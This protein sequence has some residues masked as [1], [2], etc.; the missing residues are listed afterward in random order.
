KV[1]G[2]QRVAGLTGDASGG[3]AAERFWRN[4]VD[5]RTVAI[6]GNSVREH[7]HPVDDFGDMVSDREGPET[8]NTYNMLKLTRLLYADSANTEYMEY[9]ERALYNHILASQHPEHGG[10][11]Y[12]TPM[13]PAHY[14]MY[15][16]PGVAMW[17]CVGSGME[18]HFRYGEMIYAR[19]GRDLYV[20]LFVPSRLDWT[21]AGLRLRQATGFPDEETSV[22]TIETVRPGAGSFTLR[23]RYP[24][25]VAEGEMKVAVNGDPVPGAAMP[26]SYV[27]IE[28]QWRAGDEVAISLPM[29]TRLE[30]LPDGSD[31][32]A[33]VHGPIVLAART[34][35]FEDETLE[36]RADDSRMGHRA[37]G[38]LCPAAATPVMLAAP[39]EFL[40]SLEPVPGKPL[41]FRAG[42]LS[43]GDEEGV[44]LLPFFRLHDSRYTLYWPR[45]DAVGT[46]TG[47]P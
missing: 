9:Y 11:V 39:D 26:G 1:V 44:E 45:P 18:N 38:P 43:A 7:F 27:G 47:G 21:A 31:W 10:L 23:L 3:A 28:R 12:F 14:R 34:P 5:E 37:D 24:A 4:V 22:I 13:R 17:C 6:G 16:R 46:R 36:F 29:T 19:R 40:E 32:Y 2:Y 41:A 30:Q 15:S 35:V 33:V 20:N 8:C 42:G 25:W